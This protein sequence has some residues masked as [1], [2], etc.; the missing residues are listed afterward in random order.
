VKKAASKIGG[1]DEFDDLLDAPVSKK[2]NKSKNKKVKKKSNNRRGF[3]SDQSNDNFDEPDSPGGALSP[4][5]GNS[6][7]KDDFLKMDLPR[8]VGD[9]DLDDSILGGLM[10]GPSRPKTTVVR[11]MSENTTKR[12]GLNGKLTP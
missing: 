5:Y 10:G 6:M 1:F 12:G 4:H 8:G 11:N 3:D 9:G 7:E 2:T